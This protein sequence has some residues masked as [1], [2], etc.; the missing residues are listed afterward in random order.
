VPSGWSR[1]GSVQGM[2]LLLRGKVVSC[3]AGI[4]RLEKRCSKHCAWPGIG[5]YSVE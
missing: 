3:R 4:C 1:L 5:R 2:E